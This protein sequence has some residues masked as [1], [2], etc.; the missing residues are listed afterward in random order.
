MPAQG[1]EDPVDQNQSGGGM[2]SPRNSV[3]SGSRVQDF[4]MLPPSTG[5]E[6]DSGNAS[7]TLEHTTP[8]R[9]N[10]CTSST[11]NT[12]TD[13]IPAAELSNTVA[14]N[15][16]LG[17]P[18]AEDKVVPSRRD[19]EAAFVLIGHPKTAKKIKN[20]RITPPPKPTKPVK[21]NACQRTPPFAKDTPAFPP[22]TPPLSPLS[23]PQDAS[24]HISPPSTP[25]F[26]SLPPTEIS[27]ESDLESIVEGFRKLRVSDSNPN[28]AL[29][30][31]SDLS[32]DTSDSDDA[33]ALV[34]FSPDST[35]DQ[36][37]FNSEDLIK[38]SGVDPIHSTPINGA[39]SAYGNGDLELWEELAS[40]DG[41]FP[42]PKTQAEPL[43]FQDPIWT[44]KSVQSPPRREILAVEKVNS[45]LEASCGHFRLSLDVMNTHFKSSFCRHQAVV[46]HSEG[47]TIAA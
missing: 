8:F 2:V 13:I 22:P 15:F 47:S 16:P 36:L 7:A 40:L 12:T 34:Y 30:R 24:P 26:T 44:M 46:L 11:S 37:S 5:E 25:P 43:E 18:M 41:S 1:V 33:D 6:M 27:V 29:Q 45:E 32:H 17:V 21:S 28:F 10:T 3:A 38:I 14:D 31:S 4:P 9:G 19:Y 35:Q 39:V 42:L 23:D 20:Y